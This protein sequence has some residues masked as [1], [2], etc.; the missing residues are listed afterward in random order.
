[1][2]EHPRDYVGRDP[3]ALL[4]DRKGEWLHAE[5]V[6]AYFFTPPL[7]KAKVNIPAAAAIVG[8]R[9]ATT[10]AYYEDYLA[11]DFAGAGGVF[12]K[13]VK[14]GPLDSDGMRPLVGDAI[15]AAFSAERGGGIATPNMNITLLSR[16]HGPLAGDVA[17]AAANTFDPPPSSPKVCPTRASCSGHSLSPT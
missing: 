3:R 16:K 6:R 17:Q 2:G 15:G 12:A 10:I 4:R 13:V 14:E 11:N 5:Q 9:T 7:D 8:T 1:M